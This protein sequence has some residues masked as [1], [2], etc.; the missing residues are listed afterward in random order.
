MTV[1]MWGLLCSS[2]HWSVNYVG[3]WQWQCGVCER[4]LWVHVNDCDNVGVC[5]VAVYIV[6]I[7]WMGGSA[8]DNVGAC[9]PAVYTGWLWRRVWRLV[10][11]ESQDAWV[12]VSANNTHQ[13]STARTVITAQNVRLIVYSFSVTYMQ[14][15]LHKKTNPV[16]EIWYLWNCR[17]LFLPNLHNNNNNNNNAD[18]F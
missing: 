5:Y 2:V 10:W 4:D 12:Q 18:N 6:D 7:I 11:E 15:T 17:N 1:T 16:G 13:A 14:G 9:Y 3:C 8:C